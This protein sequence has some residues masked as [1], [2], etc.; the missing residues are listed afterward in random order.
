MA[1]T[2]TSSLAA[3]TAPA[4][5]DLLV[6][7][8]V[9]DTSMAPTGTNKKITFGDFVDDVGTA[10]LPYLDVVR[11]FGAVADWE[12]AT[13]TGTDNTA[14]FQAAID[15][16]PFGSA[17]YVPP[18]PFGFGYGVGELTRSD[19]I[20]IA[21]GTR[22]AS[23][24]IA[25]P[26][27]DGW[28]FNFVTPG[29]HTEEAHIYG[30]SLV[31]LYLDGGR[32]EVDMGGIRFFAVDRT[33]IENCQ[34][35]NF[36]R[37]GIFGERSHRESTFRDVYMKWNGGPDYPAINYTHDSAT[38]GH[39]NLV[40]DRVTT[41]F[42]F[43]ESI[44][45][46][47]ISG[48]SARVFQFT[49][50]MIHGFAYT[51]IE[52]ETDHAEDG[53]GTVY[54][55]T[56]REL[57]NPLID[58][59]AARDITFTACRLHAPGYGQP[60][61][62]VRDG[63][64][65]LPKSVV[66]TTTSFGD[67]PTHAISAVIASNV[68]TAVDHHFGTGAL[69]RITNSA[70]STTTDYWV[71][72]LDED[73]FS[74]AESW[75]DAFDSTV[76]A[77][78]DDASVTVTA[79]R[80]Y[81]DLNSDAAGNASAT[82]TASLAQ[83]AG[84]RAV[85]INRTGLEKNA[86]ASALQAGTGV[87]WI[88]EADGTTRPG[89]WVLHS[90]YTT[91]V[92]TAGITLPDDAIEA[93]IIAVAGGGGGGSARRGAAGS[94]RCGGGGA[95]AGGMCRQRLYGTILTESFTV[96]VGAAGTAGAAVTADDTNGNAGGA[97]GNTTV[98]STSGTICIAQGGAAGAGGTATTGTGGAGRPSIEAAVA[99]GS[100][101]A[102]GSTAGTGTNTNSVPSSAGAGGG[103]TTGNAAVAGG[104]GG[105]VVA[106][107]SGNASGGA[108]DN[109]GTAGTAPSTAQRQAAFG[110]GA[111]GGGGGS[112]VAGAGGTGGAGAAPGG[113]GAGGG[114]S[115]NGANSGAGGVGAVGYAAIWVRLP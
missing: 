41:L 67:H 102:T 35:R 76:F 115:T 91:A 86:A 37:S 3:L 92:T 97:G 29:D 75:Q 110:M 104:V 30:P 43:G 81:I 44:H 8:D 25:H 34:V 51:Q 55:V 32:R 79:Q 82:V 69:V 17:L 4:N 95:S 114:A 113:A 98:A 42:S 33:L 27:Y 45:I 94:V 111:G 31:N 9:S 66:V 60:T 106:V 103:L 80:R 96:T 28:M 5:G 49:D 72:R 50:C 10:I 85:I 47:T 63:D 105:S 46:E 107:A 20:I 64:V 100:A 70:I 21:G 61:I 12:V 109:N 56:G 19:P 59:V 52:G 99:G 73:T 36:Q 39:N 62:M 38:D 77:V 18:A 13:Q 89:G 90:E 108:I 2:K 6:A 40:F 58:I 84:M 24:L 78:A 48:L 7:V 26:D 88:E 16:T 93:E 68:F 74:I 53:D 57:E 15:A 83:T 71:I 1:G 11:D 54:P 22:F 101:S 65:A 112:S 87:P 14:S 23:R